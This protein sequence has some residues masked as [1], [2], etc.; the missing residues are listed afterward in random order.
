[1]DDTNTPYFAPITEWCRLSGTG[2]RSTYDHIAAGHL[3]A[4]KVGRRTLIDIRAG[5]E[6]LRSLPP[7]KIRLSPQAA[8]RQSAKNG[9]E[10]A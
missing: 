1:M 7:A 9:G 6:W 3:R 5:L 4:I 10:A 2:R 8:R